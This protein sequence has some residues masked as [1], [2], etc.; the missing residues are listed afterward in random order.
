MNTDHAALVLRNQELQ[1]AIAA[2][3]RVRDLLQRVGP[4]QEAVDWSV[5]ELTA[6][7]EA[8]E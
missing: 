5:R 3:R 7:I 6:A 1:Q 2:M 8:E 4:T